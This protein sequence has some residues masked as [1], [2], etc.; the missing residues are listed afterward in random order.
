MK[1]SMPISLIGSIYKI[2]SKILTEGLKKVMPKLVDEQQMTFIKGRQIMN[3][4]MVANEC[5]DMRY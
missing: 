4:I 1:D 5:V 2:I 3:A